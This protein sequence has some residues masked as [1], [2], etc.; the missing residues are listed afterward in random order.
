M[1]SNGAVSWRS[2]PASSPRWARDSSAEDRALLVQQPGQRLVGA[3]AALVGEADEHAAPVA[4]VGQP[5]HQALLGQAVDAVR[6]RARGDQG[7]GQELPGGELV[8]GPRAPQRGQH[9][10]LPGL[11]A[12]L[13]EGQPARAVQVPGQPAHPAEH[14]EWF[15]VEVRALPAPRCDQPIDLVLHGDQCSGCVDMKSLDVK[16]LD[17]KR[18]GEAGWG[19]RTVR[20][21]SVATRWPSCL[22]PPPGTPSSTCATPATAPAPS[23]TSSPASPTSPASRPRIADLGCGPGNVTALLADRWPSAHITG[24]DNSAEMLDQARVEHA[25]PTRGGGHLDFAHAD[26]TDLDARRAVRPDRLSNATLQWVPGHVERF[27]DWIDAASRPA[28]PSPSRSPATSTPPATADARPRRPPVGRP[29][30]RR[31]APR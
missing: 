23:P 22:P 29:P 3:V 26:V 24:Y 9:V 5:L 18:V 1:L 15:H 21:A 8:R 14:L 30:H 4:G 31:P 27:A 25:G 2:S 12:V 20:T 6:H 10:E 13:G 28:A 16:S 19:T 11:Q 7:L 17:V